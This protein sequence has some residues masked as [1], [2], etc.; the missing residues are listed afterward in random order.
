[1]TQPTPQDPYAP[2]PVAPQGYPQQGYAPQGYAPQGY[3]PQGYAQAGYGYAPR[4]SNSMAMVSMISGIAGLTFLP[5]IASIVAV[6]TGT[7]AR[8]EIARTG[9]DGSGL[10]TAG[11]IMGW[12]GVGL[13]VLGL[14]AVILWFA[15]I[16]AMIGAS[17]T[18]GGF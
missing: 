5:V 17:G 3:G 1:M 14:I 16:A 8:R 4:P 9:E 13:G 18:A 12:I 11:L 15:F 6:I 10:A 7:M 2:Q